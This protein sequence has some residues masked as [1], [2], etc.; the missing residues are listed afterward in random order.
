M[1]QGQ[2]PGDVDFE[3]LDTLQ[4]HPKTKKARNTRGDFIDVKAVEVR[5]EG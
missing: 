3:I 1:A 2:C 5:R 4:P